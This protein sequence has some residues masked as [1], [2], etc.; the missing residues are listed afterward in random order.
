MQLSFDPRDRN[1]ATAALAVVIALHPDIELPGTVMT[2]G[3]FVEN[4]L[5][6]VSGPSP[7]AIDAAAAFAGGGSAEQAFASG[8]TPAA[9]PAAPPVSPAAPTAVA[10]TPTPT[11]A[12]L[13]NPG[14]VEVDAAGLPWDGRIHSGPADKRPQNADKTWRKK[15]GVSDDEVATVEAELRAALGAPP[16]APAT[17]PTPPA[18]I[19]PVAPISEVPAAPVPPAPAPASPPAAPV[20]VAPT[21]APV[22]PPPTPAAAVTASGPAAAAPASNFAELMRKITALQASGTLTVEGT[23]QISA[24]LGISGVRDLIT[25]PDLVPSFDALLPQAAA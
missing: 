22:A 24:A 19:V 15:R 17:V 10:T 16:A 4:V 21:P 7:E 2:S 18:P 8:P 12:P 14:G 6:V 9:I 1:A 5:S 13:P 11:P 25:R 20:A 3:Q 23:A